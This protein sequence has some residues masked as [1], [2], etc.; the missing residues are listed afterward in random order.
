[1]GAEYSVW[2]AD[3]FELLRRQ[4]AQI[5]ENRVLSHAA[6][7][8]GHQEHVA[9]TLPVCR[10][11]HQPAVN[12]IGHLDAGKCR[13][14]VQGAYL[15]RDVQ[16]AAPIFH[17]PPARGGDVEFRGNV[18]F[19]GTHAS[20]AHRVG[21]G[22]VPQLAEVLTAPSDHLAQPFFPAAL[23]LPAEVALDRAGV[24]PVT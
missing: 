4:Y 15:L 23:G 14:R 24:E 21:G 17:A 5:L 18:L 8:F 9:E 16:N 11:A 2:R 13:C 12:D 6:M 7:P 3:P 22:P 10:G 19:N 20:A 1:M